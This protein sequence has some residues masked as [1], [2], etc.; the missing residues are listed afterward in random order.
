MQ[1]RL[2]ADGFKVSADQPIVFNVE[3]QEQDGNKLQMSKRGKPSP[4][5]PLGRTATGKSIQATAAAFKLSWV[6]KKTKKTL[7]SKEALVNP[8]FLILRDATAEE[9]R[10]KMFEGLQNRLMAEAIPYFI[11]KDKKL[12]KLPLEIKLPE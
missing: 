12:A 11:P 5:N 1:K 8:R 9:A 4:G 3:Y 7:W 10:K 2:E 6:E